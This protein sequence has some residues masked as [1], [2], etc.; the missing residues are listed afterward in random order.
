[1]KKVLLPIA[2]AALLAFSAAAQ[3]GPG[4]ATPAAPASTPA[5]A[6]AGTPQAMGR[7]AQ[8]FVPD[9]KVNSPKVVKPYNSE[10]D[11][12]ADVAA[13]VAKA[14]KEKKRVLVTLGANWCGWCRALDGLFTKDATVSAAIAKSYVPVKVDVGR[15]TKNL[16]LAGTWGADPKK[17]G[18]PLLVVLDRDGKAV[19]VQET[20]SF[21]EAKGHDPAKVVAFLEANSGR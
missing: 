19:S 10:A 9:G 2:A 11:A 4:V 8:K 1:M 21:E 16:D 20:G 12:N 3:Q 6:P 17:N 13:A 18:I 14:K 7:P 15:M 5:A